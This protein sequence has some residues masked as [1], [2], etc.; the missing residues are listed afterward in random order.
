M[1]LNTVK[2]SEINE[3]KVVL[4]YDESEKVV[5]L[6]DEN[7]RIVLLCDENEKVVLLYDENE[8]IEVA[9]YLREC[10]MHSDILLHAY[11]YM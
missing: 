5:L 10:Y 4:L 1:W 7:E 9:F 6:Y 3:Q 2:A 11:C 8:I